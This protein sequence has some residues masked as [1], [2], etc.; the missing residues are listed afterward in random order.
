[1]DVLTSRGLIILG[2]QYLS[3]MDL[4]VDVIIISNSSRHW[5]LATKW[6]QHFFNLLLKSLD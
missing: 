3:E 4:G 2:G 5:L 1:M 6:L